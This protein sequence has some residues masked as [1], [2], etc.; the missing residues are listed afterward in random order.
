MYTVDTTSQRV[1]NLMGLHLV[2]LFH[3]I[4]LCIKSLQKQFSILG[5]NSNLC[6]KRSMGVYIGLQLCIT[7]SFP[8]ATHLVNYSSLLKM[9]SLDVNFLLFIV[10]DAKSL[11]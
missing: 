4:V 9:G 1:H 5:Q 7:Q 8:I 6:T 3:I 11:G 10:N 2:T